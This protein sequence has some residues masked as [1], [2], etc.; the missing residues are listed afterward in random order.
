MILVAR[1]SRWIRVLV[2]N[3]ELLKNANFRFITN[4]NAS[5]S[6]FFYQQLPLIIACCANLDFPKEKRGVVNTSSIARH[7]REL[8]IIFAR[9]A[10]R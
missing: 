10:L 8:L 3:Q 1:V 4:I 2:V 6:S 7:A 5:A 9:N